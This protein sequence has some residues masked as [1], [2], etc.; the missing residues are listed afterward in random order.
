MV[1]TLGLIA[2]LIIGFGDYVGGRASAGHQPIVVSFYAQLTNAVLLPPIVVLIGWKSLH[3][4]DVALGAVAGAAASLS[5]IV[6]LR[7]LSLGRM[8]VVAPVTA[9]T[10]ALVPVIIDVVSGTHLTLW[11]WVGVIVALVAIPLLALRTEVK[12][13]SLGL[14]EELAL[15]LIGGIGFA[16]F[17]VALGHVSSASGQWPIAFG[18]I[19]GTITLGAICVI[20][21]IP[22]GRPPQLA[23]ISGGCN[24]AAGLSIARAL[25]IGPIAIATV[26]GSLYPV[27]TTGL[28][29]KVDGERV[30]RTNMAGVV[31]A[32]GGAALVAASR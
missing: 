28:A 17:F 5:Y 23:I 15:A 21:R 26:M 27:V 10:T 24:V 31:L 6:F 9:I 19:A 13:T 7:G 4:G 12:T 18:G 8:S 3:G 20:R 22:V 14:A 16:V 1:V 29:A 30:S 32:A 2:S 11:R 25:Q